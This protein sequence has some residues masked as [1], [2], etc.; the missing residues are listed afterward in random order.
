MKPSGRRRKNERKILF[1]E[2]HRER[3]ISC[4]FSMLGSCRTIFLLRRQTFIKCLRRRR[5]LW[6]E[7]CTHASVVCNIVAGESLRVF[8]WTSRWWEIDVNREVFFPPFEYFKSLLY[9][10]KKEPRWSWNWLWKLNFLKFILK[11]LFCNFKATKY[12]NSLDF[13][14]MNSQQP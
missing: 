3:K 11:S 12:L 7:A 1:L 9:C 13:N 4:F 14:V 5:W 6:S 10:G 2:N 8:V